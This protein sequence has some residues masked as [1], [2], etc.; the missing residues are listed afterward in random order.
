MLNL[1]LGG[2][3][4]Q[5]ASTARD[6]SELQA[7]ARVAVG[8]AKTALALAMRDDIH[9]DSLASVKSR[10]HTAGTPACETPGAGGKLS[11]PAYAEQGA[12]KYRI[13]DT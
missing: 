2:H 9:E 1:P 8:R 3:A 4:L 11:P 10:E 5:R 7:D 13:R 6:G 12:P